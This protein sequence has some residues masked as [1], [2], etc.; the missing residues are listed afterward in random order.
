MAG[1]FLHRAL[2]LGLVLAAA[3][4]AFTGAE[5]RADTVTAAQRRAAGEFLAALRQATLAESTLAREAR[6]W[7]QRVS[8]EQDFL[9]ARTAAGS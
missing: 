8:A 7:K 5:A 2:A 1:R 3:W 9:A 6:L 4:G